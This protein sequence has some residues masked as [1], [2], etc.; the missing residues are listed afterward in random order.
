MGIAMK[1]SSVLRRSVMKIIDRDYV[2][3]KLSKRRGECKRCGQCCRGCPLL[4]VNTMLCRTYDRRPVGMCF[5]DFPL[6][7]RDQRAWNVKDCG[8]SFEK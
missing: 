7:E 6:D 1:L 8:Y 5:K 4:D 3:K 2:Q